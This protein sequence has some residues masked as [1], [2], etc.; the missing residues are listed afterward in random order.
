VTPKTKRKRNMTA[1]T[2]MTMTIR[3]KPKKIFSTL[4]GYGEG[5]EVE[6]I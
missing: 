2:S 5:F 3:K 1:W 4:N 6:D